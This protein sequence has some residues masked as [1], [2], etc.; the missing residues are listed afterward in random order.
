MLYFD[1]RPGDLIC[2]G[3]VEV[4]VKWPYMKG[5]NKLS[6]GIKA[7]K[8]IKIALHMAR[9][10]DKRNNMNSSTAAQE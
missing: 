2:I 6:L 7:D 5:G 3:E 1:V 9:D 4:I 10:R 8:E